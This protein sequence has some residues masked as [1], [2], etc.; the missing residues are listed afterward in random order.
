MR[1]QT[2]LTKAGESPGT[3]VT[4]DV[5]R[6]GRHMTPL[7][8]LVVSIVIA[9]LTTT[10]AWTL[11][12][13]KHN[14]SKLSER[15]QPLA[16]L[17]ANHLEE[18]QG[19]GWKAVALMKLRPLLKGDAVVYVKLCNEQGEET[20]FLGNRSYAAEHAV[21]KHRKVQAIVS[22]T[23][24][25]QR[26]ERM[27]LHIG[28]IDPD[29]QQALMS[30]VTCVLTGSAAALVIGSWLMMRWRTKC[31]RDLHRL[32]SNIRRALLQKPLDPVPLN[33]RSEYAYLDTA[34]AELASRLEAEK[35]KTVEMLQQHASEQRETE[36]RLRRASENHKRLCKQLHS[37]IKTL[38]MSV[39]DAAESAKE[40]MLAVRT[41]ERHCD[42]ECDANGGMAGSVRIARIG[43]NR[44]VHEL[45]THSLSA[46][47]ATGQFN[48]KRKPVVLQD[49]LSSVCTRLA[50][51]SECDAYAIA[52]ETPEAMQTVYADPRL[53]EELLATLCARFADGAQ[54]G[55]L[56]VSINR[57][58]S[59]VT[60]FVRGA[61]TSNKPARAARTGRIQNCNIAYEP[62]S[63]HVAGSHGIIARA[64]YAQVGLIAVPDGL[65]I[66]LPLDTSAATLHAY[67]SVNNEHDGLT[68]I[69]IAIISMSSKLSIAD[70]Y[71][72]V[73]KSVGPY[74][75]V[76]ASD[77]G[78]TIVAAD[79]ETRCTE[80]LWMNTEGASVAFGDAG[81]Q[82]QIMTCSRA[83][84]GAC[85]LNA[86]AGSSTY[87]LRGAA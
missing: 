47:L 49:V 22:R 41:A 10:G 80:P 40:C 38:S 84:V 21:E 78:R 55:T 65:A 15:Y 18:L 46:Q 82:L 52:P 73:C 33:R 63:R 81:V 24:H 37:V 42:H 69:V 66:T 19:D 58:A 20:F 17:T 34:F 72:S 27:T 86:L 56:K 4:P 44:L 54:P 64:L 36:C 5:P 8:V 79:D 32:H 28:L 83:Q 67:E 13:I 35:R 31:I 14:E 68:K 62:A 87:E 25:G 48:V 57:S 70:V 1:H 6:A 2:L 75:F 29:E 61:N 45:D 43:L 71:E 12:S 85:I 7:I 77:D 26:G 30:V 53:L 74:A 50:Q 11:Y 23:Y 51:I 39:L 59:T 3:G 76:R 9:A 60:L 16:L